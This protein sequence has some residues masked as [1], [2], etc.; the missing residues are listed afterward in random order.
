MKIEKINDK[1][2]IIP[3]S[4]DMKVPVILY[5]DDEIINNISNDNSINQIINV[6]EIDGI[7]KYALAMPDI[8]QGYGFPIG[9]VAAFDSKN[10]IICPGGVGF[11]INCGVR[12]IKTNITKNEIEKYIEKISFQIFNSVPSGVGSKGLKKFTKSEIKKICEEGLNWMVNNGFALDIDSQYI[13]DYGFL[14]DVDSSVLSEEAIDRGKIEIGT[15]GAGNHFLE[16]GYVSEIYDK[17]SA[18]AFGLFLDQVVIWFHT[19]SRGFGHQIAK[20]YIEKMRKK[21]PHYNLKLK[22]QELVYFPISDPLSK[23]YYLA[24]NC[25]AN[26]AYCNRQMITY[27]VREVFKNIFHKTCEELGLFL[28]YD[29][30]HNIAKLEKHEVD[31]EKKEV[32]VHRKGATRSFPAK[33]KDLPEK[34]FNIGQPVLIPGDMRRGSFILIGTEQSMIQTFGSVSHGAGRAISRNQAKKKFEYSKIQKELKDKNILLLAQD[35]KLVQEEAPLAYK[36]I[37]NIIEIL[38]LNNLAKPVAKTLPISV[39]KG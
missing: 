16:I 37:S 29:V 35:I 5:C 27:L 3:L 24:M 19:G 8:H 6:A 34:Y 21:M 4:K 10:G 9:G 20:E 12:L 25:A 15:L 28:L 31:G 33:N 7:V 13:E 22:D 1:K 18:K 26:Y 14:K 17:N 32:L 38:K 39:V 36:N 23:E 2:F 11:D 30:C